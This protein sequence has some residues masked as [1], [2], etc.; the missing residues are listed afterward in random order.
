MEEALALARLR[1]VELDDVTALGQLLPSL[2]TAENPDGD[3]VGLD[4]EV[5]T[6]EGP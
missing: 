2:I 3:A 1:L 5:L 6:R 4:I